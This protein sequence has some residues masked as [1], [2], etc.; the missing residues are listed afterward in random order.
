[1]RAEPVM[2]ETLSYGLD[3]ELLHRS[4]AIT[5]LGVG[6]EV[7]EVGRLYYG[8][9]INHAVSAVTVIV[10]PWLTGGNISAYLIFRA[11]LRMMWDVL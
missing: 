10:S 6:V 1:M 4:S 11:I 8:G 7:I 2:G 3:N 9:K 5:E